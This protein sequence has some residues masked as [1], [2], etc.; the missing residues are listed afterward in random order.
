M[1]LNPFNFQRGGIQIEPPARGVKDA[2]GLDS[3]QNLGENDSQL[4]DDDD[5][6]IDPSEMLA[7]FFSDADVADGA[8]ADPIKPSSKN[9]AIESADPSDAVDPDIAALQSSVNESIRNLR[10]PDDF[11]FDD[12][13]SGDPK[14]LRKAYQSLQQHAVVS[15]IQTIIPVMQRA[16]Q[17]FDTTVNERITKNTQQFTQQ[18]SNERILQREIPAYENPQFQGMVKHL[19]KQLRDRGVDDPVG[20]AKQINKLLAKLGVKGQ[21][22]NGASGRTEASSTRKGGDALDGFFPNPPVRR[23]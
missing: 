6:S 8:N 14:E 18:T 22:G 7:G 3:A 23:R 10:L 20:R 13:Q 21:S 9:P 15:A 17:Q 5:E 2:E 11:N 16:F 4:N 1:P 12:F 19:D